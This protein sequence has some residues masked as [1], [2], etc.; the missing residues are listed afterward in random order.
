MRRRRKEES[1]IECLSRA[2]ESVKRKDEREKD[3]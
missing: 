3:G 2:K 1:E